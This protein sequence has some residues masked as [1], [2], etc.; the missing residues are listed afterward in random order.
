MPT[1][2]AIND[3]N[4]KQLLSTNLT[5]EGLG[6]YLKAAASLRSVLPIAH[7]FSKPL[8]DADGARELALTID[9]E[10]PVGKNNE[11]SITAGGSVKIGLHAS[12]SEIFAGSDLQAPVTVPNG[13]AFSSLTLEALLKAGLAGT[14]GSIGFGFQAG[15]ALRYAY[16]HPF[17]IVGTTPAV[18]DAV[19]TMLS[20]AVFPADADDLQRLPVGAFV[21]LAGE[22]EVSFSGQATLSSTTNLLATPGLPIV[23]SRRRHSRRERQHRR[24]MDRQR[25]VRAPA[26]EAR[27]VDAAP[28]VP[29]ASRA[30]AERLGQGDGGRLRHAQGQGSAGD[31]DASDQPGS[32]GRS[33][34]A[35]ERRAG[36]RLD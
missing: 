15:T 30:V 35:R 13:T 19:K 2:I 20:A 4:G 27:C 22:G 24:G 11:L 23:G 1:S 14:Q 7:V 36:R 21:S 6:R 17:D 31:A 29:S 12:G 18:G 34:D 33:A 10:V 28:C 25:R 26:V 5:G 9:Q 8:S 16:F 32:G 3:E